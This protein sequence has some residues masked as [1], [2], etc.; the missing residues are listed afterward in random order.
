[1]SVIAKV[2]GFLGNVKAELSK[3]TW[4]TR[5]DTYGST[6]IVI[7]LVILIAIFLWAVDTGLSTAIRSILPQSL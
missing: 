4:P 1:L 6:I 5:Q 7:V 2:S 3:V